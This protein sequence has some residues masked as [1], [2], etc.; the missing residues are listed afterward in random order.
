MGVFDRLG[1]S[2]GNAMAR[3]AVTTGKAMRASPDVEEINFE[4][5]K[6]KEFIGILSNLK[7]NDKK[8]LMIVSWFK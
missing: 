3:A 7:S 5:P 4:A 2:L 1:Q 8:T 6:T